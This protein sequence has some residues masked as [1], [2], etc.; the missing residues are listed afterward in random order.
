MSQEFTMYQVDAFADQVFRGNP[1]AVLPLE[2][3]L[4]DGLMQSIAMENNL[5]ETAYFTPL[6]DDPEHDFHLRWFTPAAEVPLCGHAT[7]A[8][9]ATLFEQLGW[10]GEAIRFKSL[11]GTLIVR[12]DGAR[13]ELDFPI[14]PMQEESVPAGFEEAL[15]VKPLFYSR[16]QKCFAVLE[17]AKAVKTFKPD[18]GYIATLAGSGLIVTAKADPE[19]GCDCVSRF[20]APKYGIPE[21]PVTGS[22]HCVIVP[23]WASR[24]GKTALHARQVSKRS[25]DLHCVLEGDRVRM[26]GTA[27]LYMKATIWV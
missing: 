25:G 8:T 19:D 5:A 15:G 3:W 11:S 21:D 13:L 23:Y 17:T 14:V 10:E 2:S 16:G 9:A 7:L 12:R 26:A 22:A 4:D 27:K 6:P 18:L 1:A 20:F 24:L